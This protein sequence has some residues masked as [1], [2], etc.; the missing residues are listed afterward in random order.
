MKYTTFIEID[1]D[2]GVAREVEVTLDSSGV[3]PID[4]DFCGY[5]LHVTENLCGIICIDVTEELGDYI[6]QNHRNELLAVL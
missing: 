2:L 4:K 6:I 5:G 3:I 1:T